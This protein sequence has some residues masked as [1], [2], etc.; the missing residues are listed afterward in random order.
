MA[1]S[2]SRSLTP[3]RI[4]AAALAILGVF[5]LAAVI[6]WAPVLTWLPRAG[7]EWS[8]SILAFAALCYLLARHAGAQVD[9]SL[10]RVHR[11]M[12]MLPPREFAAWIAL[13]MLVASLGVAWYCFAGKPAGGDEIT[14]R[15][16]SRIL[17][18]G[19]LAAVAEQNMEFFNGIQTAVVDGRWFSQFPIGGAGLLALG[20]VFGMPWIINPILATWTATSV[21]RFARG[22]TDEATARVATVLFVTSPFV[23]LMS[24]SQMNHVGAVAFT[25]FGLAS[26][27][28]WTEGVDAAGARVPAFC[29]GFAFAAAA[30]LRPYDAA[31]FALVVGIFQLT[32]MRRNDVLARS[33]GWQLL[34]GAIPLAILLYANARTTGG[35]LVFGYDVLNGVAHRPGFHVDPMGVDFSLPQGVHHISAYLLLLNATLFAGPVPSLLLLI[36]ALALATRATRWDYL[37]A[38][39]VAA[40]LVAYG[41]YWAESFFVGPRFLYLGVPLF[42]LIAAR[43][44]EGLA[45]RAENPVET[46]MAKL[47]LPMMLLAAW[48][49]P[50]GLAYYQGVPQALVGARAGNRAQQVDIRP[51]M[52]DVDVEHALIFIPDSWHGR[53]AARLRAIGAPALAAESMVSS[54]DA[55][56]LQ[57]GLN[58]E[59]AITG[60]PGQLRVQ[61]VVRRALLA[62]EARRLGGSPGTR[63]LAFAPGRELTEECQ[64]EIQADVDAVS[65]DQFLPL[66]AFDSDG[67]L[68]GNVVFARDLG[69]RNEKLLARFADRTW[70]R[71]RAHRGPNDPAPALVPYYESR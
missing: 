50:P 52:A 45:A 51:A 41:S 68:A 35:P 65:F 70:Y 2:D 58:A 6:K 32:L 34:G 24:G 56:A 60:P 14:Q 47:V 11:W 27:V 37:I 71:Y 15:F 4:L 54:L 1:E 33:F 53:L 21:Y 67:R 62:G 55:C 7:L 44:P 20:A 66:Q 69:L 42:A 31:V 9:A 43:L 25:M 26:L 57:M 59:D 17:L 39:L 63:A 40:L 5:P 13:F 36:A 18:S 30:A 23:L 46:R 10:A 38:A 48:L 19:H 8:V 64:R 61:R 49:L 16:Q 29:I 28:R 22:V 12:T 3:L